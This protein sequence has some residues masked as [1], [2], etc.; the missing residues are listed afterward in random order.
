MSIRRDRVVAG[1]LHEDLIVENHGPDHRSVVLEG[2]RRRRP[3]AATRQVWCVGRQGLL[4]D[5]LGDLR[6]FQ[7]AYA[8]PAAEVAGWPQNGSSGIGLAEVVAKV[9]PTRRPDDSATETAQVIG[10]P[11]VVCCR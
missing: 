2:P 4:T 10:C 8:R 7:V 3:D 6:D 11:P 5:D 1:G 9:K